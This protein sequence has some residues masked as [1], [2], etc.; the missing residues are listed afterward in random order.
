MK[1]LV[2]DPTYESKR[3]RKVYDG[4]VRVFENPHARDVP[5][6]SISKTPLW[7]GLALTLIG[8]AWTAALGLLDRLRQPRYS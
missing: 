6:R 4:S 8:C 2:T 3:Y 7:I 5:P 1:F